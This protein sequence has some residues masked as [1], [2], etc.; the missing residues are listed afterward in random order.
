M[1]VEYNRVEPVCPFEFLQQTV[2]Q[3]ETTQEEER[4]DARVRVGHHLIPKPASFL[5]DEGAW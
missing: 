3:Q 1:D 4:V 2:G 5:V